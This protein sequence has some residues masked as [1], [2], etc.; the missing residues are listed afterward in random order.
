MQEQSKQVCNNCGAT[1]QAE[2]KYCHA[3]GQKNTTGK[4]A[5]RDLLAEFADNYLHLNTKMPRTL[6]AL[7]FRPGKLTAL[8]FEGK[9]QQYLRPVRL[10]GVSTILFIAVLAIASSRDGNSSKGFYNKMHNRMMKADGQKG[11]A[12]QID[13]SLQSLNEN[14]PQKNSAHQID[15]FLRPILDSLEYPENDS[16]PVALLNFE[17]NE[18]T[19]VVSDT[20]LFTKTGK[21]VA[22]EYDV[23][24][25]W[26][27]ILLIQGVK[28]LQ[29]SQNYE[30]YILKL[31]SWMFFLMVPFFAILLKLVYFR[32]KRFYVEH[33]VFTFH[34]HAF[35]FLSFLLFLI[36]L[37]LF[38]E[39]IRTEYEELY[40]WIILLLFPGV[41]I[42]IFVA[43]KRFYKQSFGKTFFKYLLLT[44]G[45]LFMFMIFALLL[46][47]VSLLLF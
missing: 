45:Y 22:D 12:H 39:T 29:D 30:N 25:F 10:F 47:M 11:L 23:K 36:P 5:V 7:F 14:F 42:Y 33:L 17:G 4:V 2:D 24:P 37:A 35:L 43:M 9:H 18:R 13:S 21:E 31:T 32:R 16:T 20:D 40:S 44:F 26:R 41:A 1:L 34:I 27:R 28:I 6:F 8:Y 38:G 3:C 46:I 15:S 19:L